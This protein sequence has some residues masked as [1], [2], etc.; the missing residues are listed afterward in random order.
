MHIYTSIAVLAFTQLFLVVSTVGIA[1]ELFVLKAQGQTGE[2]WRL[3]RLSPGESLPNVLRV[4]AREVLPTPSAG[5]FILCAVTQEGLK[6]ML[7]SLSVLSSAWRT[8]IFL[9]P[10]SKNLAGQWRL[11]LQR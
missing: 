5:A 6:E 11:Y 2:G 7:V 1:R 8:D 9:S 4:A 3:L 10:E